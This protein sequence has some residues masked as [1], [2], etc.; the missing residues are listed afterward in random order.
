MKTDRALPFDLDSG[1]ASRIH[2]ERGHRAF[3]IE[4]GENFRM[5]FAERRE[6]FGAKRKRARAAR[7]VPGGGASL[8]RRCHRR[9]H[10]AFEHGEHVR[11]HIEHVGGMRGLRPTARAFADSDSRGDGRLRPGMPLSNCAP[12]SN[13]IRSLKPRASIALAPQPAVTAKRSAAM[14][15]DRRQ[16]DFRPDAPRRRRRTMWRGRAG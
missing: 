12:I 15:R 6:Y 5:Q 1:M 13:N 4:G 11:F 14:H 3:Q 10:C 8:H 16:W 7:M 9:A 2:L